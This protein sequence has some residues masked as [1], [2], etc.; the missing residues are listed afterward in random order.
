M[1]YYGIGIDTGWLFSLNDEQSE[2][3]GNRLKMLKPVGTAAS[4][5]HNYTVLL[6]KK[7]IDAECARI[8][9]NWEFPNKIYGLV[10]RAEG[11]EI[12]NDY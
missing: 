10:V 7:R 5:F 3:V 2:K 4:K 6:F 12:K 8:R 11:G 1:T 9:L